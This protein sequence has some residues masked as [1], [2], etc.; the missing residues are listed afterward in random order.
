MGQIPGTETRFTT[1]A[2][3]RW[4]KL[5]DGSWGYEV[6]TGGGL[7]ID[8]KMNCRDRSWTEW[9]NDLDAKRPAVTSDFVPLKL[10]C[11]ECRKPVDPHTA[12]HG[13]DGLHCQACHDKPARVEHRG[14]WTG[15]RCR[16]CGEDE[17]KGVNYTEPCLMARDGVS[18]HSW[19]VAA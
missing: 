6:H 5:P 14:E 15:R 4:F 18:G 17:I 2:E 1:E 16:R 12:W 8:G 13:A 7:L 11:V 3:V 10:V 9:L 19:K